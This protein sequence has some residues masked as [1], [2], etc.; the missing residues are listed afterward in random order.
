MS[1]VELDFNIK[2]D[3]KDDRNDRRARAMGRMLFPNCIKKSDIG[4]SVESCMFVALLGTY[5]VVRSQDNPGELQY[6]LPLINKISEI[7]AVAGTWYGGK[8]AAHDGL[9]RAAIISR[10]ESQTSPGDTR[11]GGAP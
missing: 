1:G 3:E 2:G 10:G 6:A 4:S 11:E 8:Y 7:A 5:A 9:S